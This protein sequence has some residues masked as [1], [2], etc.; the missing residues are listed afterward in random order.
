MSNRMTMLVRLAA[1]A[2]LLPLAACREATGPGEVDRAALALARERWQAS[3]IVDYEYRYTRSCEC[4]PTDLTSPVIEV[5][6][7][8]IVRVWN[9]QTG[10]SAPPES[11]DRYFTV[12]DLFGLIAAA[13]EQGVH[14][15]EAQYHPTRGHPTVLRI[16]Y[17]AQAADEELI[18]PTVGPV[19][20][21]D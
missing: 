3:G 19:L 12:A 8:A 5:R 18:L 10:E 4:L 2:L 11:L 21:L 16:D 17:D 7:G 20:P 9:E 14:E 13:I 1:V 15:L 6:A